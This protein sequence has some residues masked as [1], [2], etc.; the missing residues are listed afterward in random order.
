LTKVTEEG[1]CFST[2]SLKLTTAVRRYLSLAIV[3]AAREGVEVRLHAAQTRTEHFWLFVWAICHL[4][5]L[6]QY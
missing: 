5:E 4:E 2:C 6:R 3:L 1:I